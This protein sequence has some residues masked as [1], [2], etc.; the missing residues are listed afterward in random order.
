MY[1]ELVTGYFITQP[2]PVPFNLI[3]IRL[4]FLSVVFSWGEGGGGGGVNLNIK[5]HKKLGFHP[6][7]RR[8]I[9]H[10][11]VKAC[12]QVCQSVEVI[13]NFKVFGIL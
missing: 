5:S 2:W 9:F 10:F 11:R 3:L 8:H 4:G 6:L 12:P 13:E 1:A 7:F